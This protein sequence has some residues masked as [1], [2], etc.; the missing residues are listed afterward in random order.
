ML[1]KRE[2]DDAQKEIIDQAVVHVNELIQIVDGF[3]SSRQGSLAVTKLEEFVMWFQM[4]VTNVPKRTEKVNDIGEN[5]GE[6]ID[7][8]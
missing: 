3:E 8:A 6:I 2:I 7:A 5:K 4:M 1:E